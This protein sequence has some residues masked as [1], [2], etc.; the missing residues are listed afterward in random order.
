MQLLNLTASLSV[1]ASV[2]LN[3]TN[4][5]LLCIGGTEGARIALHTPYS[6]SLKHMDLV[7]YI[8][9]GLFRVFFVQ[10]IYC[11]FTVLKRVLWACGL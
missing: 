7:A 10:K 9:L 11:G 1:T 5:L 6:F 8:A 4:H 3:L 2:H